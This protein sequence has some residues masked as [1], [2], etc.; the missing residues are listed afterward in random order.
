[1]IRSDHVMTA[2]DHSRKRAAPHNP[3]RIRGDVCGVK[4]ATTDVHFS[5]RAIAGPKFFCSGANTPR[6]RKGTGGLDAL[7]HKPRRKLRMLRITMSVSPEAAARYFDSALEKADYYAKSE[8]TGKGV[9]GGQGVGRLGLRGEVKR[10]HFIRL[11]SLS[12]FLSR[13]RCIS[14]R[15]KTTRSKQ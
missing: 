12:A 7:E 14:Q 6:V 11:A 8:V 3:S 2:L 10:G 4:M 1:V 5:P 9:W 13:C 15:H